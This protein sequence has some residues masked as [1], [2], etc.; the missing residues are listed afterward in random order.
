MKFKNMPNIKIENGNVIMPIKAF[1][2][3]MKESGLVEEVTTEALKNIERNWY[4]C[5]TSSS[6][7][8]YEYEAYP[9]QAEAICV[10]WAFGLG[11]GGSMS[12]GKCDER[13]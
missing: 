3:L 10:A 8:T 4:C 12:K 1:E 6:N 13:E 9:I 11:E 5:T 7:S 2:Q